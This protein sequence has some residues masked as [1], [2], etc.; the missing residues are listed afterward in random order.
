MDKLIP[1][2]K[3]V[4]KE[5]SDRNGT[6]VNISTSHFVPPIELDPELRKIL[7][8]TA[9][10]VTDRV[11]HISSGAGHDSMIMAKYFP[12]AMLFVPSRGGRSHCPEEFSESAD[13]ALAV[14]VLLGTII[15]VD[16]QK[17]DDSF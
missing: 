11:I 7:E 8:K 15:A 4:L 1:H 16:G 13:L 17:R 2:A 9:Q 3:E 12:T 6:R 14:D 5:I 10:G